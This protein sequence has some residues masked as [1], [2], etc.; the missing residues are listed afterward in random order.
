MIVCRLAVALVLVGF[1]AACGSS[2]AA[3]LTGSV[4]SAAA[5]SI[6]AGARSLGANAY[7]PNPLTI[8]S[9]TTVTWTNNDTIAHTSTSDTAGVFD[10]GS[11]AAGGKFS[12]TL[13]NRGTLTYHCSFH[14]GMVGTIVVQ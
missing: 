13:V 8:T 1:L 4:G 14:T 9:G 2:P 3:P 10:S 5:V 6:P 7:A 11:I 12:F